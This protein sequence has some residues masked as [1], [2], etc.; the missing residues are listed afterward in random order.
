MP[1]FAFF[2]C[3]IAVFSMLI[4]HH[5]EALEE[6]TYELNTEFDGIEIRHYDPFLVARMTVSSDFNNAGQEAHDVL[7]DYLSGNNSQNQKM[8]MAVPV[9]QEPAS[10]EK[11]A[12]AVPVMQG[13]N[14]RPDQFT[15]SFVLPSKY[16]LETIPQ[17]NDP[18][19][20]VT[21]IPGKIMAVKR[22]SGFWTQ[23]NYRDNEQT[24]LSALKRHQIRPIDQPVYARYNPPWWPWFMRRNEVMVSIEPSAASTLDKTSQN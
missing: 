16:T 8:R 20:T 14:Q 6:P 19:V 15:V 21:E 17:P 18:R 4:S 1:R 7:L 13:Q 2:I 3:F 5:V 22:Y 23:E 12:M 24:L 10:G 11:I 9:N